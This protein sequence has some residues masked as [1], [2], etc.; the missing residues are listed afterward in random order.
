M[1]SVE[2]ASLIE[3]GVIDL[4]Y[5]HAIYEARRKVHQLMEILGSD[6]MAATFAACELTDLGR[7]W[8]RRHGEPRL[9]V[10]LESAFGKIC[11]VALR[12]MDASS[13]G[14]VSGSGLE[15]VVE[16]LRFKIVPIYL[17]SGQIEGLRESL[18]ALS[19]EELFERLK[20]KNAE[21]AKASAA[22]ES[23]TRAKSEFIANMSH[24]IRTPMNAI[25]GMSQLALNT[26]LEPRQ[27]NFI[28]KVHRSAHALL[29]I[30]NDI[31][32]FSKIEAGKLSMEHIPFELDTP[33]E[34]LSTL[35]G[36]RAQEKGLE[37]LFDIAPDVP[38]A[39]IGD[40]LRIEQILVNLGS[41]AVKFTDKGEVLLR[42]RV[43]E[44][45]E[46][47]VRL[48]FSV[49]DTG[50]G[51]S[52]EQLEKLFESFSQ[53]DSSTTRKYGGTGLGLAICRQLVRL[54]GGDIWAESQPGHGSTFHFVVNLGLQELRVSEHHISH[55]A[56]QVPTSKKALVVDDNPS[57][58]LILV[59]LLEELG[60]TSVCAGS[61]R[62]ALD[63]LNQDIEGVDKPSLILMDMKMPDMDGL[64]CARQMKST[65]GAELP[66]I[67]MIT[68]LD[69][70][71]IE[72][73]LGQQREL[74]QGSLTKPITASLL[75]AA[76]ARH[77][78]GSVQSQKALDTQESRLEAAKD[79]LRGARVLLVEDNELNQEL[80]LELLAMAEV[81][82]VVAGNGMEALD[83]MRQDSAFDG[84]LMDCQM[85]VMDGYTATRKIRE[86][87]D[88]EA[89]PVLAMTA[90]T[91][92][93]DRERAL[94]AGMN[95]YIPKPLNTREM[96]QILSHWI[97][98]AQR[99]FSVDKPT[100][101]KFSETSSP[102]NAQVPFPDELPGIDLRSALLAMEGNERMYRNVLT[103]FCQ[104]QPGFGVLFRESVQQGDWEAATRYAHTLKG[105]AGT[106]GAKGLQESARKL[107]SA[108]SAK[109]GPSE[110]EAILMQTL[111]QLE[112]VLQG[113]NCLLTVGEGVR[114][115]EITPLSAALAPDLEQ[116][117]YLLEVG[118]A[119]AI[120]LID[121]LT[122]EHC[123]EEMDRLSSQI[124][125]MDFES[126][127][128]VTKALLS[129]LTEKQL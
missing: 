98:P 6:Y 79:Q 115:Q 101:A 12:F 8:V 34:S 121:G 77:L 112:I 50:I 126:A 51:I 49:S 43:I 2:M 4:G 82:C 63:I 46:K 36:L 35:V 48:Q 64:G 15:P 26:Q 47:S 5:R 69:R 74:I 95:D 100:K 40:P 93:G 87:P 66:P 28:E 118:D 105:L 54:M 41:N 85:P 62:Q 45:L 33:L 29:G 67:L 68:S 124:H 111:D 14:G 114:T 119:E 70:E 89:L 84:V 25:I 30:I 106:I 11:A 16:A 97:K 3:L 92:S 52:Q 24:E 122:A 73:S 91:M 7:V 90:N 58:R 44:R 39:L 117:I 129:R 23:A 55:E 56:G 81:H 128:D 86:N 113:L 27:R 120:A 10:S 109:V 99:S 110:L 19:R 37:L 22:A 65:H 127:L 107:E 53:A 125:A 72:E 103:R 88:W 94:S 108:S 83:I 21:L 18:A 32:D 1:W 38:T 123:N 96:F 75:R 76:I 13:A 42:I 104:S 17:E 31:L 116:L 9:R 80:A 61:G 59:S 60:W 71:D 102:Q 57:A 78:G 20:Q